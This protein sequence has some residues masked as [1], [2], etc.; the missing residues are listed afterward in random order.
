MREDPRAGRPPSMP[1]T[2]ARDARRRRPGEAGGAAESQP[3]RRPAQRRSRSR[4]SG[5]TTGQ[6]RGDDRDRRPRAEALE[7]RQGPLPRGR[8]H[9]GRGDRLLRRD[10]A[11]CCCPIS[12]AA[13]SRSRAGPTASRRS[14]SSRS[15]RPRTGPTGCGRRRCP[16]GPRRS[17]TRSPTTSPTLVW[18]AN[19]AAIE[20][21]TPLARAEATD[22]PTSMV[23]DLD[24]GAPADVIDCARLAL[25][26]Q[27]PVRAARPRVLRQ[28]IGLEGPAGLRPAER[29]RRRLR[30]DQDLL[31]GG[32]RAVRAER[33][34]ARRL[35]AD[36][37][38]AARARC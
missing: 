1:R 26:L 13:R 38:R 32:R 24:P 21:H 17:T 11:R 4:A 18:L 5:H 12:P 33:A 31:E 23:F 16:R 6:A 30:R 9:E 36:A 22:R 20:L 8:L 19:L 34:R 25:Q 15:S 3:P 2:G 35:A 29:R 14:P 27:G 37:R 7:P 28:D 10:L